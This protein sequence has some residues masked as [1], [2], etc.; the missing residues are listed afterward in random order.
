MKIPNHVS[1]L[2]KNYEIIQQENLHNEGDDLYGQIHY[3]SEKIILNIASTEEQKKAT[4]IHEL[5]HG[6][7]EMYNI[8]LKE[9]QVEKLG[10]A[11]YMMVKDNPH[12]FKEE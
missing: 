4:L 12:M 7:D 10:N 5:V 11:F 6:L 1:I 9:K 8:G 3:L 2:Y